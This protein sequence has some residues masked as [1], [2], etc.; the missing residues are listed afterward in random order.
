MSG[1]AFGTVVLHVA[2]EGDLGPLGLVQDGDVIEIDAQA[3]RLDLLVD[4]ETLRQRGRD[5][6]REQ[7]SKGSTAA[8]TTR[9]RTLQAA[10]IG[11]ADRG[12]DIYIG[13]L[14]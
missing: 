11:Q 6:E 7:S 10:I 2:P 12:A 13:Q 9:W 3:R 14:G 4:P 8:P 1:T 5:R